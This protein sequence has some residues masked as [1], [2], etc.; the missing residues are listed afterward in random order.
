MKIFDD[1]GRYTEEGG[2]LTSEVETK[3]HGIYSDLLDKGIKGSD[4][5]LMMVH[6]IG[7]MACWH[8]VSL[9]IPKKE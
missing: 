9:K 2:H 3:L 7:M 1:D 4:A 5:E 8:R 6:A